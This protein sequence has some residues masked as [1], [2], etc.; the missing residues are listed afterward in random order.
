VVAPAHQFLFSEFDAAIGHFRRYNGASLRACSPPDCQLRAMLYLDCIGLRQTGSC[1]G[2]A[3]QPQR[4][5]EGGT[6]TWCHYRE[7]STRSSGIPSARQSALC[8]N[9]PANRVPAGAS[10]ADVLN[11]GATI[12]ST[13]Q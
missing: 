10:A 12:S 5:S 9:V 4:R 11:Q 1:S 13:P 6:A 8:G 2:R 3:S 7:R